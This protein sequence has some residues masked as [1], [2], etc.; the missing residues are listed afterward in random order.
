MRV[1]SVKDVI[2]NEDKVYDGV[3][4]QRIAEEIKQWDE[5]IQVIE[6]LQADK[7]EDI[8]LG[9]GLEVESEITRQTDHEAK[10]LDADNIATK[11]DNDKLTEGKDW[12]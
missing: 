4:L 8:Q 6:L 7:L 11:T 5:P 3:Q 10:D 9:E 2:F 1:V 12:K